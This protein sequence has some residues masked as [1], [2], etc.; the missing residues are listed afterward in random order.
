MDFNN[1]KNMLDALKT[2]FKHG[3]IQ[4]KEDEKEGVFIEMNVILDCFIESSYSNQI[5]VINERNRRQGDKC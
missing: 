3:Y 1:N 5:S 4:G 2:A